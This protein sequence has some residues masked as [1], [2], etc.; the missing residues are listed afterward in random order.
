[1][2][3]S[4]RSSLSVAKFNSRKPFLDWAPVLK[5]SKR[6]AGGYVNRLRCSDLVFVAASNICCSFLYE[7]L[8][9][10]WPKLLAF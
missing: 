10:I 3:T 8:A 6:V 1:M 9:Q 4:C 2:L 5:I 7:Q